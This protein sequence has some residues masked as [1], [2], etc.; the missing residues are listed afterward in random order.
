MNKE[1]TDKDIQ[2]LSDFEHVRKRTNIYLG[3]TTPTVYDVPLFIDKFEIAKIEFI[4]AVYK[5]VG[6]I[7]DNSI[8]EFAQ[9]TGNDKLL[10]IEAD[11]FIGQYTII[12]NGRG[13]PIGTHETGKY[14]PE[15]VFGQLRSGRNFDDD[16]K[17]N[18]PKKMVA[19]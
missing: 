3:S 4:P 14:T 17:E 1:Y 15:V 7:L 19:V 9:T 10:K 16:E 6:E 13:V 8:D 2:V 12:D 11:P 18:F 5:A